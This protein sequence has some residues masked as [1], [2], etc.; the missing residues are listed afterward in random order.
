MKT[1]GLA[2]VVF[3]VLFLQPLLVAAQS[4]KEV[5]ESLIAR[6]NKRRDTPEKINVFKG[7]LANHYYL[8]VSIVEEILKELTPG[9]SLA[10]VSISS[11]SKGDAKE[12]AKMKKAGDDWQAIADKSGVPLKEAIKDIRKFQRASG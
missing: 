10:A 1:K 7:I 11:L 9:D 12:V 4:D 2:V 6:T 3:L 5:L 8:S